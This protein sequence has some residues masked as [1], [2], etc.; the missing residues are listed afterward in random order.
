MAQRDY[1]DRLEEP[2]GEGGDIAAGYVPPDRPSALDD[3]SGQPLEERLRRERPEE[4][5]TDPDRSGRIAMAGE[6]AALETPDALEAED[7]GIDEAGASAEEAAMHT[8]DSEGRD[9]AERIDEDPETDGTVGTSGR[10][11]VGPGF[12]PRNS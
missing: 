7:V 8:F 3:V 11:D 1:A 9:G 2:A 10:D 4:E 5:Q 12:T 6:G